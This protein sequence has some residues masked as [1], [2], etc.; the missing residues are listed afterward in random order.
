MKISDIF[1]LV[2]VERLPFERRTVT[3]CDY[4]QRDVVG[5]A[6]GASRQSEGA[7]SFWFRRAENCDVRAAE[8]NVVFGNSTDC[9]GRNDCFP[10]GVVVIPDDAAD[11]L[12]GIIRPLRVRFDFWIGC[13][14]VRYAR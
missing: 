4:F 6:G 9:D 10:S 1:A 5:L 14:R 12:D 2:D 11:D 7:V 8:S 13:S 3:K